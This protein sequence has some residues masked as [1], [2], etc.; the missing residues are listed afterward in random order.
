MAEFTGFLVNDLEAIRRE[1]GLPKEEPDFIGAIREL[2]RQAEQVAR[3]IRTTPV[4][5]VEFDES[6]WQLVLLSLAICALDRPGFDY[7]LGLIAERCNGR[8]PYLEFKRLNADRWRESP[9][10]P[11]LPDR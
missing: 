3:Y 2:K 5:A 7:A 8:G 4:A 1:L 11:L 6:D 9:P 10:R